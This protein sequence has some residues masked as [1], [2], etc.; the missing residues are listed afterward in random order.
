MILR[1]IALSF[2][3]LGVFHC[4]DGDKEEAVQPI[5]SEIQR[6]IFNVSCTSSCHGTENSGGLD[7]RAD[8]S[9]DQL[10]SVDPVNPAARAKGYK[11]VFPGDPGKSFLVHKLRGTLEPGMGSRM[12]LTGGSLSENKIQAIEQ[13]IREGAKKN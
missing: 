5:F 6:K 10:F 1:I 8:S 7:L 2:L 3:L 13:W 12:P 11:R 4:G 9:Y